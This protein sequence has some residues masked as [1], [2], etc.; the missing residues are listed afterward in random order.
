MGITSAMNKEEHLIANE[1]EILQGAWQQIALE[2]DGEVNPPDEHS[3]P[4]A[5][6]YFFG[7][8]FSVRTPDGTV[9]IE[10]DFDIDPSAH[11]KRITW[12]DSIGP[13]AGKRLPAIYAIEGDHFIFVATDEGQ[14]WPTEFKTVPGLTMRSFIRHKAS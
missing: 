10:G 7:T 1:I 4:G 8:Q 11:P 5:L 9:L 3:V 2:A 6:C 14:P 12:I 13:D